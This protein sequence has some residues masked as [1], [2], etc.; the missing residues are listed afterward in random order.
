VLTIVGSFHRN[1]G[2]RRTAVDACRLLAALT[3]LA[4][5]GR[6]KGEPL[7]PR[8]LA[9]AD[10]ETETVTAVAAGSFRPREPPDP[11]LGLRRLDFLGQGSSLASSR[12]VVLE[13][14]RPARGGECS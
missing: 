3:V 1:L 6:P 5:E 4:L 8:F 14:V 9:D 10:A 13:R 11:R 12:R 7:E 2:A